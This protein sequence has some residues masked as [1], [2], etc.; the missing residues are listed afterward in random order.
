MDTI[1]Y[2]PVTETS[3]ATAV[4]L[5]IHSPSLP[6]YVQR[7][8]S[9]LQTER[10]KRER[11]YEEMS[12]DQ[13]VEFINGEIV[14]QSPAKLRHTV[15]SKNLLML[16]DAYVQKHGLG[17]VG[18]EKMLITLTRNDYEPDI[19]YFGPEKTQIFTPD[20]M[21]FPAPDLAVEI[22]SPST[23]ANDRG[24]KFV[25]YAAHGVAEYWIVDPDTEMIEQYILKGEAYQLRVKTD[26]GMVRSIAVEGLAV[27]VRAVFDEA[28]KIAAV[29]EILS[30]E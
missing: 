24:I 13:K 22:L 23:E 6:A 28:E 3:I 15:A 8:Q 20:Q 11:F 16:L 19:C 12:E 9:L 29:R 18:H 14:M 1:I 2:G 21:K 30:G 26:T 17:F 5:L 27:P 7:F 10:E 25:D 4:Q